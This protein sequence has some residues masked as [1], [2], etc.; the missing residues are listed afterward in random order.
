MHSKPDTKI[1][2]FAAEKEFIHKATK[3]MGEQVSDL[4]PEGEGLEV[5]GIKKQGVLGCGDRSLE[6]GK[7]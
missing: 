5:Y 2:R 1:L 7:R 6:V 3:D 4:L